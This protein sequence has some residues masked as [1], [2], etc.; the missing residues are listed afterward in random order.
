MRSLCRFVGS[1]AVM[2][3]LMTSLSPAAP[4][5]DWVLVRRDVV[6]DRSL[7]VETT[8]LSRARPQA[9]PRSGW[10][11]RGQDESTTAPRRSASQEGRP[12]AWQR[13][14]EGAER[15]WAIPIPQFDLLYR[16]P[17]Y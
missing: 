10:T 13:L 16:L 5:I 3:F 4:N 11:A 1:L 14:R 9:L 15:L 6:E 7:L 12:G 17:E 8:W 2:G